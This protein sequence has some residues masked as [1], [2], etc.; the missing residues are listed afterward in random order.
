MSSAELASTLR[1]YKLDRTGVVGKDVEP[2]VFAIASCDKGV[3]VIL[4]G[5]V[6]SL[7]R[8]LVFGGDSAT[9]FIAA[10]ASDYAGSARDERS[11]D[12]QP[13]SFGATGNQGY[14]AIKPKRIRHL[15]PCITG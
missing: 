3:H 10:S 8:Q 11:G 12:G 7:K 9:R 1:V 14:F 13:D 4:V 15:T 5:G 2:S 6:G